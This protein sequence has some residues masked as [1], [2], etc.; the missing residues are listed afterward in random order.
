M[1]KR[2]LILHC[3]C[4]I[5]L[6][7]QAMLITLKL[8]QRVYWDKI[9]QTQEKNE[10]TPNCKIIQLGV[11]GSQKGVRAGAGSGFR[12]NCTWDLFVCVRLFDLTLIALWDNVP[13]RKYLTFLNTGISVS[14]NRGESPHFN[15]GHLHLLA[16]G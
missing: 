14:V 11:C 10:T 5:G 13:L 15:E 2:I 8:G 1:S 16:L 6:E 4:K 9:Y 7:K 3:I 12:Q